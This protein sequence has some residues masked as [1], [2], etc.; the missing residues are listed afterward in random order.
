MK[1]AQSELP[2]TAGGEGA[3]NPPLPAVAPQKGNQMSKEIE[4]L[5]RR[6]TKLANLHS[7]KI[8]NT[9]KAVLTLAEAVARVAHGSPHLSAEEQKKIKKLLGIG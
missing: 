9:R 1:H 6:F 7:R 3:N 4:A 8:E 5:N 2:L